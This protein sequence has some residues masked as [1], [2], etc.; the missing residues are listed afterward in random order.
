MLNLLLAWLYVAKFL[1]T[2]DVL[3]AKRVQS[4]YTHFNTNLRA[5]GA[6]LQDQ[7]RQSHFFSLQN[8]SPKYIEYFNQLVHVIASRNHLKREY[9]DVIGRQAARQIEELKLGIK[10]RQD[11]LGPLLQQ[12]NMNS[13]TLVVSVSVVSF[14]VAILLAMLIYRSITKPI[15]EAVSIANALARGKL[16]IG[17]KIKGDSETA[18]LL[19][20][21]QDMSIQF[22][23]VVKEVKQSSAALEKVSILVTRTAKEIANSTSEQEKSVSDTKRATLKMGESIKI[24]SEYALETDR[25]AINTTAEAEDGGGKV[26]QTID[27]MRVIADQIKIIDEIAYQTNLLALNATIEASRAGAHGR[28]FAVVASEVRKLAERCQQASERIGET[29][30]ESVNLVEIAGKQLE[31]IIPAANKTSELVQNMMNI[32]GQQQAGLE[33]I[34]H[35]V[36]SVEVASY[37]NSQASGSLTHSVQDIV[38]VSQN[39]QAS[40]AFFKL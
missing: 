34:N 9:L 27:A 33:Q 13:Q 4:E 8:L 29:A 11:H 19:R 17:K 10:D 24:N 12:D 2:N 20:A 15:N 37:R 23:T 39:L 35:T 3:D 30:V 28:G 32:S 36:K 6:L 16:T 26:K 22:S 14:I 5:L 25:M 21:L 18:R 1:D 7:K 40:A 38:R 31:T